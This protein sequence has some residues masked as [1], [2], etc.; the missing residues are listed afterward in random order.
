MIQ[1]GKGLLS[2]IDEVYKYPTE[3]ITKENI[4]EALMSISDE[5]YEALWKNSFGETYKDFVEHLL[6]IDIKN[7]MQR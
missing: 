2:Q 6:E 3:K 4:R 7:K 1:I 5:N